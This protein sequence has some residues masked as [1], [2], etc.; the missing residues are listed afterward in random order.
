MNELVELAPNIL[1][2]RSPL[3]AISGPHIEDLKRRAT[4][5]PLQRARI[6]AHGFPQ[7]SL[8]EMLIVQTQAVYVRPHRHYNKSESLHVIEGTAKI[9]FFDDA[10]SIEE[11]LDVGPAASGVPFY[12][13]TN[14]PRWH[15]QIVQTP[16]FVFQEV[17][18]GPLRSEDTEFAPW[19]PDESDRPSVDA[20]MN[21]LAERVGIAPFKEK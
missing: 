8:H 19:A 9:V 13:R 21:S 4:A 17:T 18:G 12:L 3:I 2:S 1:A 11:T 6:L 7:D 10:G 5:S 14:A 15:T 20:F 16:F